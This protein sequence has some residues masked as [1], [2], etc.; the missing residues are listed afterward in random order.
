MKVTY[1]FSIRRY[2]VSLLCQPL[3]LNV[4]K[5]K[6]EKIKMML[7]CEHFQQCL[8]TNVLTAPVTESCCLGAP[9]GR[10]CALRQWDLHRNRCTCTGQCVCMRVFSLCLNPCTLPCLLKLLAFTPHHEKVGTT[11]NT[12]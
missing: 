3:F 9:D 5:K 6:K 7:W 4:W 12:V 10:V 2:F 1:Q 11:R 8:W